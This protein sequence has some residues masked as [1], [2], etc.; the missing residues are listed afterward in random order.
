MTMARQLEPNDK[1]HVTF[2]LP[3]EVTVSDAVPADVLWQDRFCLAANKPTGLLVHGDGTG[4]D[5]LTRRVAAYLAAQAQPGSWQ[6]PSAPQALQRLDVPTSGIVW[7]SLTKEFQSAFDALIASHAMD[8]WY[9]AVVEGSVDWDVSDLRQPIA[10]DR[11]DARRMRVGKT[12]KPAHTRAV[13]L[14]RS[15]GS[16]LVACKLLTGRRHQIR[17]HLAHAGYAIT[18]DELYGRPTKDGL[19]L[20]AFRTAFTHPITHERIVQQT[21]WPARFTKLF[22]PCDVDWSILEA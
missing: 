2:E 19:M 10:R 5:T 4:A 7:F 13:C 21:D 11:H 8:K 15:G 22:S 9:L 18:G 12:G 14:S 3:R 17:V 6:V 20:H 16:T 1:V